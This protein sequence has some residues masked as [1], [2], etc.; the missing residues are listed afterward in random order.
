M[1]QKPE[2]ITRIPAALR[3]AIS[4]LDGE[5]SLSLAGAFEVR[6]LLTELLV[7]VETAVEA[8]LAGSDEVSTSE[9]QGIADCAQMALG[10][11][12]SVF[13]G[14]PVRATT[15]LEDVAGLLN[16]AR[17]SGEQQGTELCQMLQRL[18]SEA[19]AKLE[20]WAP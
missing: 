4:T 9:Y 18:T 12:Y 13:H 19:R 2:T 1:S 17:S 14:N 3:H 6:R 5:H 11:M 8:R 7:I 10:T 16:A 15:A 20:G